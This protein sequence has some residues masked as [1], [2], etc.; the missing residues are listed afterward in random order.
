ML[1][2]KQKYKV[3]LLSQFE[4]EELWQN[5]PQATL[6]VKPSVLSKLSEKVEYWV[7]RKGNEN[8]CVWP[9]ALDKQGAVYRPPF[10]YWVG[11][12][13]SVSGCEIPAHRWLS[14][15]TAVYESFI[16]HLLDRYGSINCS[17]PPG[18]SDVRVFDWWNYHDTDKKRF[19]ISPRYTARIDGLPDIPDISSGY[20]E[21][22]RRELRKMENLVS[23]VETTEPTV[24]E[25][26]QL[27]CLTMARQN[28]KINSNTEQVVRSA[29]GLVGVGQGWMTAFRDVESESIVSVDL[30][31]EAK[32]VANLLIN[33]VRPEWRNRGLLPYTTH[34]AIMEARS[35]GCVTFDF[36][37]ANSPKRGDDKHSYGAKPVLYFD[38]E[39]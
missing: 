3:S 22:R 20:R 14:E 33:V 39:I 25:I 35:R 30:V 13:W 1:C 32:G 29:I 31:L 8:L 12:F 10:T 36:N 38:L 19:R 28:K 34:S 27:Y 21:L 2:K 9:V 16:E 6:F 4:A 11:P 5:S 17:L 37:G 18:L 15:S 7:C 23:M 24:D 26:L